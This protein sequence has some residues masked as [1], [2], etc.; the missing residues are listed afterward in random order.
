MNYYK[1]K[2]SDDDFEII[3]S[4]NSINDINNKDLNNK[5]H[6]FITLIFKIIFDSRNQGSQFSSNTKNKNRNND[7][8]DNSFQI[9][10]EEL[11]EYDNSGK[12][13]YFI[14]FYLN[15]ND[16]SNFYY[17]TKLND[18]NKL[19]VERWK[20]KYKDEIKNKNS[21]KNLD[22]YLNKKLKIIEKS[23]VTYSRIL[24][25][26]NISKLDNISTEFEYCPKFKKKFGTK[27]TIKK[28]KLINDNI[29]S[30]KLSIKYLKPEIIDKFI[31][32]NSLDGDNVRRSSFNKASTSYFLLMNEE[33][34]NK[35]PSNDFDFRR[36]SYDY[37]NQ[38][39]INSTI[40]ENN[41]DSDCESSGNYDLV[42]KEN[43][44]NHNIKTSE[45]KDV[46]NTKENISEKSKTNQNNKKCRKFRNKDNLQNIE[47]KNSVIK[48]I[49]QDFKHLRK[50]VQRMSNYGNINNKKLTT[51]ISNN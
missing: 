43:D 26:F 38:K 47:I 41:S 19:F 36:L 9:G 3:E 46:I 34:G 28:I 25:V 42:I 40:Q 2:E 20:I 44:S 6:K 10:F 33:K 13:N 15:K 21:I 29:F 37:C 18:K 48:S 49:V 23:V 24:P 4:P 7:K 45:N 32:A 22:I 16:I 5:F 30:F 11:T 50:I 17:N 1:K 12:K 27:S 51:F 8:K 39:Y 14:D 35:T 31:K